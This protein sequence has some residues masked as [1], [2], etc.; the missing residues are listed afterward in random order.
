MPATGGKPIAVTKLN[1]ARRETT[2]RFPVFLP[3]GNHFLY[4]AGSHTVGTESELHAIYL[5]SLDGA[6]P[7]R[8]L[9]VD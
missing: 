7:R 9:P 8:R 4:E 1:E 2:H 3:D 5:G 6:A